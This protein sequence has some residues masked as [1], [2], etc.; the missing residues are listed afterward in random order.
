M[1]TIERTRTTTGSTFNP[2]DSS[3]YSPRNKRELQLLCRGHAPQRQIRQPWAKER[4]DILNIVLVL[5]PAPAALVLLG[6][7]FASLSF[8]S[9][10]ALLRMAV[11]GPP[12]G[13]GDD[14]LPVLWPAAT[15]GEFTGDD[16]RGEDCRNRTSVRVTKSD[17]VGPNPIEFSH[18]KQV[19][20]DV[21]AQTYHCG[22]MC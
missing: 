4:D 18:S 8:W 1:N 12:G 16:G 17:C 11:L 2:G 19:E 20:T 21:N 3:V 5:P 15:P 22:L 6:R 14:G 13:V 10:A 9:A 7:A